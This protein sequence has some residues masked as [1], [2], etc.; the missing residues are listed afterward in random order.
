MPHPCLIRASH[1]RY[2][3]T[4]APLNAAARKKF[5]AK[6]ALE[7]FREQEHLDYGFGTLLAGWVD[8]PEQNFPCLPPYPADQSN[9]VCLTWE[10]VQ[11][12]F[13]NLTYYMCRPWPKREAA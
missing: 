3:L 6:A 5:N 10:I 1:C 13:H 9:G 12:S 7:F 8:T 2:Q 4:W 11:V